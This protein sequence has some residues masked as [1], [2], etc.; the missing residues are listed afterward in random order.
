MAG[1]GGRGSQRRSAAAAEPGAYGA[2]AETDFVGRKTKVA[3]GAKAVK[4]VACRGDSVTVLS[5]DLAATVTPRRVITPGVSPGA[6]SRFPFLGPWDAF[7]RV[8]RNF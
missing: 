1:T 3:T 2:H 4:L 7:K 5:N 8:F 6:F